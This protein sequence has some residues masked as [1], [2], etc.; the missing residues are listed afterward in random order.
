METSCNIVATLHFR[1]NIHY[2]PQFL[3]NGDV[4]HTISEKNP[5]MQHDSQSFLNAR[6]SRDMSVT[7][8]IG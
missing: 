1:C 8:D 6:A 2:R 3:I 4:L 5:M 7:I